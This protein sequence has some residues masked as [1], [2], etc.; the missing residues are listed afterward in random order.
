MQTVKYISG[1]WSV[2]ATIRK[3][4]HRNRLAI[5]SA[6]AGKGQGAIEPKHTVVF[7]HTPGCDEVA[8]TKACM[9]GILLNAH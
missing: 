4:G 2:E 8:E 9:Q 3:T 1:I 5:I 6:I 7:E